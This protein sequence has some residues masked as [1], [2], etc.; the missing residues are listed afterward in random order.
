MRKKL[1]IIMAVLCAIL[2]LSAFAADTVYLD[3]TGTTEGAYTDL[4]SAVS[5]LPNGGTVIVCGDTTVGS[6]SS[7]VT[8]A[9]VN[10]KVTITSENG[11]VLTM[12][13]SLTLASELEFKNITFCN[14]SSSN[15]RIIASGNKLTIGEGVTVTT[16]ADLY[17]TIFGG[18]SSGGSAGHVVIK[19]GT[20]DSVFGGAYG[21][22]FKGNSLVE[23]T[24]GTVQVAVVGGN[25][26]GGFVG[27]STINIGGDAVV[28]YAST[29]GVIGGTLGV[30]NATT[31]YT[32]KG[33]ITINVFGKASVAG[34]ILGAS[35]YSNITTT[36]D[37][38]VNV[39][40]NAKLTR[41]IYAGGYYGGVTTVDSGIRVIVSDNATIGSNRYVC[42]GSLEKGT[43][44]GYG[45]VEFNGNAKLTGALYVGG[46]NGS[47]DGNTE[48]VINGGTVTSTL[49]AKS[50]GS[51]ATVSGTQTVTLKGGNVGPVKG[52][53]TV[54]LA[55]GASVTVKSCDGTVTT[56]TVDG[57]EVKVDGTTYTS[58]KVTVAE[59]TTVYVDGTGKTEGA[60]TSFADAFNA[61]SSEGGTVILTGDTQLGTTSSGVTLGN[62]KEFS[63]KITITSENGARLI[64]ARS[65]NINTDVE[66]EN[67]HIHCII[68]SN[69][70]ANNS[71]LVRGNTFTVGEGVTMTK[72]ENAIYPTIIGGY[73]T[74]TTYDS[75]IVVK[76]GAWQNIYGGG[77]SGTFAGDSY[78]EVSNATVVGTLSAGSRSGTF[79]GTGTLV[80]DLR[81]NKTVSASSFDAN[82]TLLVDEGYE[83]VLVGG[84]YLQRLP[85]EVFDKVYV[86][87][88]GAT[89]DAY[90]TFAE[91]FASI[92]EG[93]TVVVV[94]DTTASGTVTLPAG[95][96]V[97][98]SENGA[99]LTIEAGLS[100]VKTAPETTLT[101]D[102]AVN[103]ND[104][105]IFGGFTNVTFTEN[106]TV[107]GTLDF[108]GGVD[109]SALENNADAITEEEY[110]IT[111]NG[112][113]FANF[114][115]GNYRY[116]YKHMVGSLAAPV[117]LTVN[118]GTFN[119]S[120][121]VSGM[122]I[123]ADDVTLNI[124]G[125]TFNC[126]VYVRG[127]MGTVN[128]N[129]VKASQTV[130]SDSKY[131]AMDGD[132]AVNISGGT[133]NG[134]IIGAYEEQTAYT[135]VMRGNYTVTVSGGTFANGTV[136]DATQVKAYANSDK[137]A[138]ITYPDT[139]N[140]D[141]VRFDKV[142]GESVTYD[143]P[144]RI[145]YIGDS[146][147]EGYVSKDRLVDSYP[148]VV[149]QIAAEKGVV[150]LVS[151]NYGISASG[152]LNSTSYYFPDYL[153]YTLILEETDADYIVIAIGTND[154]AAGGTTGALNTFEAN[155]SNLVRTVGAL[156]TTKKVFITNAIIR[157]NENN[158]QIRVT[159]VVRPIQEKTAREFAAQDADKYVFIDLFRL[160]LPYAAEDKLLSSD[161]LHPKTA[162]YALMADVLYGV[163][164]EG[165][166]ATT[167]A[168]YSND[169]YV[170]ASGKPFASGTK[171]DPISRLD[172]AFA[173]LPAGEESTVH[174]I[175]KVAFAESIYTPIAPSKVTI[176]GE[177]SGAVLQ[178]GSVSFKLGSDIKFDNITLATTAST[179]FYGCYYDVEM[180]D[181]VSLTGD[182]S[183]F[184]GHNIYAEGVNNAA[185][186]TVA[187]ASDDKDCSIVL[188]ANGTFTNFALGNRRCLGKAP[189]GTYS[190]NLT[191]YIGGRITISGTN[192]V[193]IVGQNYL[194]GNITVEMPDTLT[195]AEYAPTYTVSSP[196]VYDS[197]KNTGKV[198]VTKYESTPVSTTV[199]LDGT[200]NTE[201]AYTSFEDAFKA[202]PS[203]GGTIILTGDTQLGTS[204]KGVT[205]SDYNS[206]TG[207]VTITSENGA[208]LIFARSLT[209]SCEF[210]FNNINIHSIA[211]GSGNL[212]CRGNK[213]TIGE[214]VT[215]TTASGAY[216]IAIFGGASSGTVTYDS[217]LVIRSGHFRAVYAGSYAGT[218][219][220][221]STLEMSGATVT[222]TVSAGN[223]SGTYNGTPTLVFDLRGDKTVTAGA[224]VGTPTLL[225]DAGLEGV[226]VGNT[227]LQREPADMTPKTV[228]VDGTGNT[229]GAYTSFAEALADMPGGG[230]IVVCGDVN[231][232][233]AI[234]LATGG[235]LLITSVYDGNDYTDVAAIKV[236][237]D[238]ELGCDVTFKDIV[239]DKA[240]TGD[241]F[242]VANGYKLVI[243]EGVYCRNTLATR[244]ISIVGGAKSGTFEGDSNVTVKSGYFRNIFGGNY[245]GTFKG[246]STVNFLGGYVDNMIAGGTFMGNFEGSATTNIGGDAVVVYSSTGSGVQ[247]GNCGSGNDSYTFS[248]EIHLNFFDKARVNQNVYGTS[249]Y[250][251][252]TT[253][254]DVYITIKDDAFMYQNLYAGGYAGTLNG[255]T[256]VVMDGGWVGVNLSAGNRGGTVNGNTYLEINGGQ[257]N[258][259]ATNLHSSYSDVPGEYNVSGGGLTGKV[260][261]NTTVNIN[262]GN[263]YGNVYGG[264]ITTGTVGGK[265]TV[266]VT[267]GSIMCGIYADGATAGSVA[268]TKTLNVDLSKGGTLAVGLSMNVNNLIGGGKL[269]LFPEATVTANT[270]SGNVE[271]EINGV[272][273]ARNYISATSADGASVSYTA[274]GDEK[275]VSDGGKFGISSEGYYAK[276]KVVYKHL[277]GV[278]IYPRAGIE[279]TT[280]RIAADEKNAT[281][282]VFYLTPGIYNVVVYHTQD[283]YKR[284][285]LYVKGD[286]EEMVLDYTSYTPATF[287][288]FEALHF[289]ENT[290]EI[291]NTYYRTD[292][293]VGYE[294]PD[295]PFFNNNREGTRRFTSNDEMNAFISE[296][297]ASCDYA[298]AFDIFTTVGGTTVPVVIFTK[299]DIPAGATLEDVAKTVT[300]TKGRDIMMVV[301]QAHGNEPSGG[302]GA[303]AMI[304]ELCGDYGDELLTGN[305]GAVIIVPRLNP[306]GSDAFTRG[307]SNGVTVDSGKKIDNL[308]RDYAMLSGPEVSGTVYVFDLF[309]PTVFVDCHEAPLDPQWGASNTLTDIYDVGIMSSGS[310]NNPH[311]DA[312]SVIKGNYEDRNVRNVDIITDVLGNIGDTGLRGYYYQTPS[313]APCNNT[314]FGVI[315][316]AY[317]FLIEV[318]GISGG[319]A[320]FARRVFAQVT[321]L[322]SIFNYAK[323]SNGEMAREVN[324]AREATALSAQKF[325]IDTPVVLQHSY[326]R[327]DSATFLWNNPLVAADGTMV[328]AE[329]ITKYY[330]QD[331]AMKYRARPTAYVLSADT[332]GLDKVLATLDRQG[333]DYYQLANGTTL[334]LKQY[335]GNADTATLSSAKSV[336]FAN[337]AYIIPVD[338]YRAY[339][340]S[341]LFEPECYDSGEEIATFVQ[342]GYITASDIYRSEENYVAAKLGLGGTYFEVDLNGKTIEKVLVDGVETEVDVENGK[343]YIVR[344]EKIAV[345]SFTD[346]TS[347]TY[348]F[349]TL[350]GD[351]DGDNELTMIDALRILRSIVNGVFVDNGDMNGDSVLTLIDVIRV[352]KELVK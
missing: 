12:A 316:G 112:G 105:K 234:T 233:S 71:I 18:G 28:E 154:S 64:F 129:G 2:T 138:T 57:Y 1:L 262:G 289:F 44:T 215:V 188:K 167:N 130:N 300:A 56:K 238:I 30:S 252:V 251:N 178:N 280:A 269:I 94:G 281:S 180:T 352:F 60:Y 87:G 284:T 59:P 74:N 264:A 275:F 168:Y 115:L 199:Y 51:S 177:G 296:K 40:E 31:D 149:D 255:N 93:A 320:V 298:Y 342:A 92:S 343:A 241:D 47:F 133:F 121:S 140:F 8:L 48:V 263:I 25:R 221:T 164:F 346:G 245:N 166:A 120:F 317:A 328:R 231:V 186:D 235:E 210:E 41:N 340:I 21:G 142:N 332:V 85:S 70:T 35:R 198:T 301:A 157:D 9:K 82:P 46:Y 153:A 297:V 125:G 162:G 261:G 127:G 80:L 309:A 108:F 344:A 268:G 62:Y 65:L 214:G 304:S 246:N 14:A 213:L 207:K 156:P 318:P 22:T 326:T 103:A 319:D 202:L 11:A 111:V 32:F 136:F 314:P 146:I 337:G 211:T 10:G 101:L 88:T 237:N 144:I 249:R 335:S 189:F 117:T 259:Y 45:Y 69:L 191:A 58:E 274:K 38:T 345:V 118:G 197:A 145:A 36:G 116:E 311:V 17:P 165:D 172:L 3:G 24:G 176:V 250:A 131:Y 66:F 336:T 257:I 206:F 217:H 271:L 299:D 306:D 294:T 128:T 295:S 104:A 272:P 232:N 150:D 179:E 278:E 223:W 67:I 169:V 247:G 86:D 302:E 205:V 212:I 248:G 324:D 325:D 160:T 327:H 33:D 181:T 265:S 75:H 307:N 5:A 95:D 290:L 329:N 218:F 216:E 132:V 15:G 293:L 256:S 39:Y 23:I 283:D 77:F 292:N 4:K 173:M 52:D 175:G 42:A 37:I 209:I 139:Y 220:G 229:E 158:G 312:A 339:F 240:A 330:I 282:T 291:Y 98:T 141:V 34:N 107:S 222:G 276:T 194:T 155:Y 310:L 161:N 79:S 303:L 285:Y 61:L 124:S 27:N 244:Y 152:I 78:V 72:D 258:Y 20:W 97:I 102:L 267:G 341:V 7:G 243:D 119:S 50:C 110:E 270:F 16:T 219:N 63:G 286:K 287:A 53:A 96:I 288:G 349:S 143:E 174:I 200:G 239:L 195:L 321:A 171:S 227:Y 99:V 338:G 260:T 236:A 279:T 351:T 83:G 163:I 266:T 114:A 228:H 106:F 273:Q 192:Y 26:N 100:F 347:E 204:S 73:T 89:A 184:A 113:T 54:D 185:H 242:I 134:G 323:N 182:W 253:T 123:I 6:S 193:G 84:T 201:G 348:R 203:T 137:K 13:R 224:Y 334:T 333:I 19:S 55:A 147:T 159:S 322:K 196:I 49:S 350:L 29:G 187:S 76:G 122:A 277:E 81:G 313:T 315:N 109:V 305:V 148:A 308:N 90:T 208:K 230:T 254:A 135:Q 331:V 183:F 43:V 190:G 225:V 151:S 68:P 170:S 126:P 91:A 226:L